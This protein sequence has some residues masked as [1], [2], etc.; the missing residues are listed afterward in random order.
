M[1][2]ETRECWEFLAEVN[3]GVVADVG[4]CAAWMVFMQLALEEKMRL[5]KVHV[6][7]RA[8]RCL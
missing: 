3:A 8:L 5:R 7:E 2:M 4:G 6:E 1:D